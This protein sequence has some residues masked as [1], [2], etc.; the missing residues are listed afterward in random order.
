MCSTLPLFSVMESLL[1]VFEISCYIVFDLLS[2]YKIT[3]DNSMSHIF[4]PFMFDRN[5]GTGQ[6][7]SAVAT[8]E[9]CVAISSGGNNQW[10]DRSCSVLSGYICER[11]G[12]HC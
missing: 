4:L 8:N 9:Q 5:W 12:E 2:A 3:I 7:S 11:S 6:P 1:K 10:F